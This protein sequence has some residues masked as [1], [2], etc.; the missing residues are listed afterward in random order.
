MAKVVEIKLHAL[1]CEFA[2]DEGD[3]LE[4]AGNFRVLTFDDPSAVKTDQVLFDFPDGPIKMR[5]GQRVP[6]NRD[7][8]ISMATPSVPEPPR[9]RRAVREIGGEVVE[10][11]RTF[12]G[13]LGS[14]WVTLHTNDVIHADPVMW[15]IYFGKHEE[16]VR[17]DLTVFFVHPLKVV[18]RLLLPR[19]RAHENP[20]AAIRFFSSHG[21]G[22]TATS[23]ELSRQREWS[24]GWSFGA[25]RLERESGH[26][27][28]GP[29]PAIEAEA[30]PPRR[31]SNGR[32][33]RL[34]PAT[35]AR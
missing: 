18:A 17:A 19:S 6:I 30:E 5:K 28:E 35:D 3:D 8:R 24:G 2:G 4:V 32:T 11:D 12:T 14:E 23:R 27:P 1:T 9:A 31:G 33:P 25:D 13:V 7:V 15:R 34:E 16:I 10:K 20:D 22:N 29:R 26:P 21:D